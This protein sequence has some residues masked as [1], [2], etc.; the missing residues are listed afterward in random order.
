MSSFQ[1]SRGVS[2]QEVEMT[3]AQIAQDLQDFCLSAACP[4]LVGTA[5]FMDCIPAL[6]I[7]VHAAVLSRVTDLCSNLIV[8]K[9]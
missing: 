7:L 3:M 6:V 2:W 4:Y 5:Q 1:K 9:G 8:M